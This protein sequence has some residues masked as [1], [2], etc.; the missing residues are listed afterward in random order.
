MM[1]EQNQY[2][3]ESLSPHARELQQTT[4]STKTIEREVV[5][6]M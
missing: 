1:T 6:D 2:L 3:I 5:G 4:K